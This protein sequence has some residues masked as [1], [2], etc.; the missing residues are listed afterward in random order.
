MHADIAM[1]PC[2]L[3]DPSDP[4]QIVGPN[5]AHG[6]CIAALHSAAIL[7]DRSSGSTGSSGVAASRTEGSPRASEPAAT[8][9][10]G[11]VSLVLAAIAMLVL[12]GFNSRKRRRLPEPGLGDRYAGQP[13]LHKH[14]ESSR[15]NE[16]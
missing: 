4:H 6:Q 11:S 13:R 5:P 14:T 12:A 3:T 7:L 8:A 1:E 9:S 15:W 2:P 16:D 10:L